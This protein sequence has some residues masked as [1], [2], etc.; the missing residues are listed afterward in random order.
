MSAEKTSLELLEKIK[1]LAT[2]FISCGFITM[3]FTYFKP[4]TEYHVPRIL[5]PIFKI[6]GNEGL[7]IGMILLGIVLCFFAYKNFIKNHGRIY[8]FMISILISIAIFTVII[9]FFDKD[10]CQET[11]LLEKIEASK[12]ANDQLV[13]SINNMKKPNFNNA[14]VEQYILHREN[15]IAQCKKNESKEFHKKMEEEMQKTQFEYINYRNMLK[16]KTVQEE[17]DKYN[18]KLS[19]EWG[20]ILQN[21]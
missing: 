7:A 3:G 19:I 2:V 13:G 21:R 1:A 17:F 15:I 4:Q 14:E 16:S 10:K 6:F 18:A 5:Y 9:V 12:K 8:V 11:A 20:K